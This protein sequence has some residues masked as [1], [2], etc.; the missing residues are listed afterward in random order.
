MVST[1]HKTTQ[2]KVDTQALH[3]ARLTA[4]M[5]NADGKP[6]Q[7]FN[8]DTAHTLRRLLGESCLQWSAKLRQLQGQLLG[9]CGAL[10]AEAA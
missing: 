4:G 6:I 1:L 8:K 2:A 3:I 7:D 10:F 9:H 5:R